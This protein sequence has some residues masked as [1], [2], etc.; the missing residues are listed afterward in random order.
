MTPR[1]LAEVVVGRHAQG[2]GPYDARHVGSSL[3]YARQTMV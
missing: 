1:N 2:V 3:D